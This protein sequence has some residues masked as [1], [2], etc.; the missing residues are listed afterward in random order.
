MFIE[1]VTD[2]LHFDLFILRPMV[3]YSDKVWFEERYLPLSTSGNICCQGSKITKIQN[4]TDVNLE[5]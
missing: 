3:S 2:M 1:S 5:L 4:N